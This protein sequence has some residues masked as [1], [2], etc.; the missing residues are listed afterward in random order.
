[1]SKVNFTGKEVNFKCP[2]CGCIHAMP[3]LPMYSPSWEFN[4]DVNSPTLSPSINS[5]SGCYFEPDCHERD[6]SECDKDDPDLQGCH[7]CHFFLRD[8]R[9]Q[10]LDDCTHRLA[11]QTVDLPEISP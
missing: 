11:G 3:V 9:V 1:M 7:V 5:R 10:F 4:N 2:G 6:G 8:G